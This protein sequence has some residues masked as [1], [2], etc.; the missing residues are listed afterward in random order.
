MVYEYALEPELIATWGKI[1]AYRYFIDKF[2]LG[3]PRLASAYPSRRA[4]RRLKR[5]VLDKVVDD[6]ELKRLTELFEIIMEK[7]LR[8]DNVN[9]NKELPWIENAKKEDHER[10]FQLILARD[11]LPGHNHVKWNVKPQCRPYRTGKELAKSV[12]AMLKNCCEALFIDPYFN[13]ERRDFKKSFAA[14]MEGLLSN[15]YIPIPSI[16]EIHSS[17]KVTN[18]A[19]MK[20]KILMSKIIPDNL[21]VK[22]YQWKEKD[23][24]EQLKDRY[25]LTDIGGVVFAAGLDK[26]PRINAKTTVSLLDREIYQ[27]LWEIYKY[28][29]RYFDPVGEIEIRGKKR[30]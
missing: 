24:G 17:N 1:D 14:F 18:F 10:P 2:G 11:C 9:Y 27:E 6:F 28:P 25:I 3:Q 22:F 15:R 21:I 19:F 30:C 23:S 12:E 29:R 26:S 4:Y 13:P 7:M 5:Q 20:S 16:V 8:R